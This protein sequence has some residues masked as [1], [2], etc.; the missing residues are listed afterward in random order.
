VQEKD[1]LGLSTAMK[2]RDDSS[3][4]EDDEERKK[5]EREIT[6]DYLKKEVP[7]NHFGSEINPRLFN[8]ATGII[9]DDDVTKQLKYIKRKS[10]LL[11]NKISDTESN[12]EDSDEEYQVS[13]FVREQWLS[14]ARFNAKVNPIGAKKA[15]D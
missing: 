3:D 1:G 4:E 7:V 11:A 9:T 8:H 14:L 5:Q 2:K 15:I 13:D 10:H 6:E 12:E